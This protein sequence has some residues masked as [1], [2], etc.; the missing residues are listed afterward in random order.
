M[1]NGLRYSPM[2]LPMHSR[3]LLCMPCRGLSDFTGAV[4]VVSHNQGFMADVCNELW[5]VSDGT[6]ST[7]RCRQGVDASSCALTTG[8]ACGTTRL[9]HLCVCGGGG[10]AEAK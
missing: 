2:P 5:V 9:R 4:V 1:S 10:R 6:I 8:I 3:E 7:R